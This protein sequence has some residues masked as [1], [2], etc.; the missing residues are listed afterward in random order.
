[1]IVVFIYL[2]NSQ[3][4]SIQSPEIISIA[5][6]GAGLW[7]IDTKNQVSKINFKKNKMKTYSVFKVHFRKGT[8]Y[9]KGFEGRDWI[10]VPGSI[11]QV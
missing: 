1:M 8:G 3:W 4:W 2:D 11:K 6:G 5:I 9:E 10:L 7:A